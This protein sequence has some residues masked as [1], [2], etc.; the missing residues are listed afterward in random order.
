[1][2]LAALCSQLNQVD[3]SEYPDFN[4]LGLEKRHRLSFRA[5]IVDH[6]ARDGSAEEA[7]QVSKN[8][9]KIGMPDN[10]ISHSNC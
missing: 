3:L 6:C 5:F 2:A 4:D 8:L 1:M 9:D 10:G 7:F